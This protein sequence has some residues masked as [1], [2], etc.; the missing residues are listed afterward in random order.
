MNKVCDVRKLL[1]HPSIKRGSTV[2]HAGLV[3]SLELS[4]I[5]LCCI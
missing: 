2:E 3:I 4:N 1:L 5:H